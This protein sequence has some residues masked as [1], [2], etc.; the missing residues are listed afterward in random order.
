MALIALHLELLARILEQW[1]SKPGPY[2]LLSLGY[3]DA[4]ITDAALKSALSAQQYAQL[5]FLPDSAPVARWHGIE[6]QLPR[7]VETDSLLKAMGF[8]AH[9]IDVHPSRGMEEKVD[10]NEALPPHLRQA[11]DIV[12]DLGTVEHC[13]NIGQA[14]MNVA[15]CLVA[16]GIAL[17]SNPFA[18]HDHGFYNLT[19]S[20]YNDFYKQNGFAVPYMKGITFPQTPLQCQSFEIGAQLKTQALPPRSV[21]LVIAQRAQIQPLVWPTQEKYRKS[22]G[23]I[24]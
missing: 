4:L 7:L 11:F 13:F 5:A 2:R 1:K 15:Q 20:F 19:P 12:L 23:L 9:Y 22:P 10:L 8:D 21:I 16:G 24:G 3:P 14:M 17:H 18:F 6:G